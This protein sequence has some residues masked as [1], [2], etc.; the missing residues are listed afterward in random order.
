MFRLVRE[1]QCGLFSTFKRFGVACAL[2]AALSISSDPLYAEEDLKT[3]T[4]EAIDAVLV[5]D[6]SGSMLRTDPKR[7]RD[8]GA[9]LFLQFLKESDR[10][11]VIDF[12]STASIIRPL[13]PFEKDKTEE[14]GKQVSA[15]PSQGTYTNILAGVKL[16]SSLL[17][18]SARDGANGI[19]VLLSDG[20]MEPDPASGTALTLTND[21]LNGYL[22]E[23]KAKGI[24]VYTLAL[25]DSADKE[26]LAS[27]A[28]ATEGITWFTETPEKIHE[29]YADL[30]L[31]VKKPQMVPLTGKGFRVDASVD[32][33]TFYINRAGSE[34]VELSS[35]KGVKI[36]ENQ[37]GS[38]VRWFKGE[39]FDVITVRSPEPG[40]WQVVGLPPEEGFAT[41]L[42]KLK[43]DTNWPNAI[44]AEDPT[45]LKVR[46][47]DDAKPVSLP[48]VTRVTKVAYQVIPTDQVSA[49]VIREFL[50]DE[51][52][53]GD[54]EPGDGVFSGRILL[55]EPGEYRLRVVAQSP[56]FTRNQQLPFRVKP[57]LITLSI[58][59]KGDELNATEVRLSGGGGGHGHAGGEHDEAP[60]DDHAHNDSHDGGDHGQEAHVATTEEKLDEVLKEEE[61]AP[62]PEPAN[63]SDE[64]KIVEGKPGDTFVITLSDDALLLKNIEVKFLA[65]DLKDKAKRRFSLPLKK[66]DDKKAKYEVSTRYIPGAGKYEVQGY[67][68][69]IGRGKKIVK[70]KTRKFIYAKGVSVNDPNVSLVVNEEVKEEGFPWF[71]L[72][73]ILASC[74]AATGAALALL[75]KSVSSSSGGGYEFESV[76]D[77]VA[78]IK[79]LEVRAET[80]EVDFNG[81][82][83][84]D[85]NFKLPTLGD[86]KPK[87]GAIVIPAD[88][89]SSD[90]PSGGDAEST[91]E[92]AQE[93]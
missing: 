15:I 79:E 16:A 88:E 21:L 32:E 73:I 49:P 83:F 80:V 60:A 66:L 71:G 2:V 90:A 3:P 63:R 28:V 34:P 69:G 72:I 78:L 82:M 47:F 13:V 76:D 14:V 4:S 62:E 89:P 27:I 8:E 85:P 55:D 42:T 92:P 77:I 65:V 35:P 24:K 20:K 43:I 53:D 48:E 59:G 54:E 22:P 33:A 37:H 44:Y 50:N 68:S 91:S 26:L 5:L 9:K 86:K 39:K 38:N 70:A 67:L 75:K 57:P 36:N 31:A 23:L 64:P 45:L 40:D 81:P 18:G 51:G 12:S 58:E 46:L 10:L 7:L 93:G 30:F 61:Q 84:T 6:S 52:K 17:E 74:G 11:A 56:T 41:L 25:S 19:I 87:E 1:P 29:S